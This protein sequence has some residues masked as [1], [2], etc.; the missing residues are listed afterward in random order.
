MEN[1]ATKTDGSILT[2]EEFNQIPEEIENAI[3]SSGQI[4]SE[5]DT[6]QLAKT[7]V[8]YAGAGSCY[9]VGGTANNLVLTPHNDFISPIRYYQNMIINFIPTAQ[10]TD[11]VSISISGL[12]SVSLKDSN[13]Q[14][15]AA[16][17]LAIG[18]PYS[19]FFNGTNFQLIESG[20]AIDGSNITSDFS[21]NVF[22]SK[23]SNV[24][25]AYSNNGIT[26]SGAIFTIKSGFQVLIP[27]GKSTN[28]NLSSIEIY[29]S[30]DAN[31]NAPTTNGT[32]YLFMKSDKSLIWSNSYSESLSA[33]TADSS[34]I[35][36][37]YNVTQNKMYYHA[38]GSSSWS[39]SLSVYLGTFTIS[40]GVISNITLKNPIRLDNFDN[41]S[42]NGNQT[43]NDIKTF[44]SSPVLPTP[45]SGDNSTKGAT[46]AFV[47]TLCDTKQ[48]TITG[49]ATTITGNNLT[50]NRALVS[51][52]SGKVAVSAVTSVE[53]GYLSGVT[54]AVQ[55]QLN[56]KATPANITSAINTLLST[57]YPVGSLYITTN[58]SATCPLA[59]LMSGSTWSLVA[60][61]KALWTSN[62]NGNTTINA[63]LPNITGAFNQQCL[64][65]W[66]DTYARG[67]LYQGTVDNEQRP[68]N[69][70]G[71][72]GGN[73]L[74]I[75][76][77]AS[78][79]NSIYGKSSTVQ[80][81]AY[82]VNVWRRTA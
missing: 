16:N 28:N 67:A 48:A 42:L 8:A 31:Y 37:Y 45:S 54:S 33:P 49:A 6:N 59:S 76:F 41:V 9:D 73:N 10:N 34:K 75:A 77:N 18:T 21:V 35:E 7:I 20:A 43:I 2:P 13:N 52:A 68:Q 44:T 81:P 24:I 36:A 70:G 57:L 56:A 82:R 53:L 50:A 5:N 60:A 19:A 47:K 66:T 11:A 32:Y 3:L 15:L 1:I 72:D 71:T 61:D 27:N 69:A 58:N 64:M 74:T 55:T 51:N 17:K 4:L 14:S 63:G 30:Q 12:T 22:R 78:K 79:S 39:E 25:L 38:S 23:I 26:Y 65:N 46:T 80:P 40:S 62:R 29:V